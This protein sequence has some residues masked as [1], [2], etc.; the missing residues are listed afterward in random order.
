MKKQCPTCPFLE[1]NRGKPTPTDFHCVEVNET[2]WY[3]EENINGIWDQMK[4]HPIAFLSCHTT[5][6]DYYGNKDKPA[7]V[8][9]GA[10]AFIQMHFTILE[11]C[12]SY[13]RYVQIVGKDAA[14]SKMVIAEKLM[15]FRFGVTS[16][17]WGNLKLPSEMDIDLTDMR[18][19]MGFEKTITAYKQWYEKKINTIKR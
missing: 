13:D 1:I 3:S 15:A 10:A 9:I 2:D 4:N 7:Y 12:K 5:D 8:C 18:Y 11:D 16:P 19:P 6:P 17:F 14:L